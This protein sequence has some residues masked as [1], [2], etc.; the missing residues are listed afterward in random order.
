M[1]IGVCN[2]ALR[3]MDG[4]DGYQTTDYQPFAV[5]M[6]RNYNSVYTDYSIRAYAGRYTGKSMQII[7]SKDA[8]YF[9]KAISSSGVSRFII[10]FNAKMTS[11]GGPASAYGGLWIGPSNA[12]NTIYGWANK[13]ITIDYAGGVRYNADLSISAGAMAVTTT[14]SS[15]VWKHVEIVCPITASVS[16]P[17]QMYIDGILVASNTNAAAT[18]SWNE[19]LRI[20][21]AHGYHAY[22]TFIVIDDFYV[23]DDTGSTNNARLSSSTYVPRIETLVPTSDVAN[24]YTLTGVGSAYLAL[25]N[26]PLNS[27]QYMTSTTTG[28]KVRNGF[29]DLTNINNI[30]GVQFTG[31]CSNTTAATNDWKFLM[32]NTEVGST[33]TVTDILSNSTPRKVELFETNPLTSSAWTVSDINSIEA[34]IINK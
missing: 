21:A 20:G 3:F 18:I 17:A 7:C 2:M 15:S 29:G 22:S 24:D 23:L 9:T 19:T 5:E 16:N 8:G 31:V 13:G 33:N 1:L 34:G 12:V 4:F 26:I 14:L 11:V 10:G 6:A 30:K 32:N 28:H 25:D 27:G